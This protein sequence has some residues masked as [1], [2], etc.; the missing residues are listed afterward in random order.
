MQRAPSPEDEAETQVAK[1][2]RVCSSKEVVV[3]ERRLRE[4]E[5]TVSCIERRTMHHGISP[6]EVVRQ[7]IEIW[8]TYEPI[9]DPT[10]P[11]GLM[12]DILID[13]FRGLSLRYKNMSPLERHK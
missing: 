10:W 3:D 2:A 13:Y 7:L 6:V 4:M 1:R 8:E 12:R 9:E 5:S 11:L